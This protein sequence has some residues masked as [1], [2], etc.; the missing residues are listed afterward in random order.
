MDTLPKTSVCC[1]INHSRI[2]NSTNHSFRI[3][4]LNNFSITLQAFYRTTSSIHRAS[5]KCSPRHM[6]SKDCLT[7]KHNLSSYRHR[8]RCLYKSHR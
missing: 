7:I 5:L 4:C 1:L 6:D 2:I 8:C 3:T